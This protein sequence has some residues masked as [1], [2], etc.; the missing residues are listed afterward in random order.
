MSNTEEGRGLNHTNSIVVLVV[1]KRTTCSS[2]SDCNTLQYTRQRDSYTRMVDW[3]W[4]GIS[5]VGVIHKSFSSNGDFQ[6][7]LA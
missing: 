2:E 7:F 5:Y 1:V 4:V 3:V 6:P